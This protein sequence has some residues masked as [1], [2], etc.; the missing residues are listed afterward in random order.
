MPTITIFK[1]DLEGLLTGPGETRQSITMEQL[2]DSLMLVKGELKGQNP[3]SGELR[4]ELQD[5]NRPDLW[6]CEGI[7]RQIR[8]K[9]QGALAAY[10]FLTTKPKAL[11]RLHVAPGMEQVR[12]FVAA[13][14]ATGYRVT[15]EGLAQLI[16]T[17]EKLAEMFGRKRKTV[18][19]G[20]YRLAAIEFPIAYDL[21][22]P[23]DVSFMP[24]GM[25]TV[26]TL[27][28]MLLVHPKG[29]EFGEILA[30]Q[31]RLPVLRDATQQPLSFPPII[32]SREVGEVKVG[33][34]ALFVEVT[35]TDLPM[36]VLT[37]NIFAANLADRGAAIEPIDVRYPYKTALGQD[38][39]TPQDLKKSQTLLVSTIE[40]ALGQTLGAK[41]V[42]KAL[43]AY[44]Y[45][46]QANGNHVTVT[47]PPYRQDLMHAMDVVEDVAISRGYAD[48]LPV[49]PSDFTVGGLSRI[50]EVSDRV[51]ALMVGMGFQ[52]II[53]NILG[54]PQDLRDAMRLAGT[55]WGQLVEVDN[56]MSQNF[57]ALRQWML[58]SLLRV[59][60]ASNRAFYP[61]RLFEAGEVAKLDL[62][63]P[64]GSRTAVVLGGL[65]AHADAHFSEVHSCLD[66][67]FYYVNQAYSLEPIQ[68]P[69]FL[70]GRV[71]AI[72][73]EGQQIG[74]IGELHPEVL[75][76]WQISVPAVAF[77]IELTQLAE[78]P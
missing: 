44:G 71:G 40:Q 17:Q 24:L 72:V 38:V 63:Q 4:I 22:K 30:G 26:M 60:T 74:V 15:Q 59:E 36:V 13:C 73:C 9:R 35:G 5:S 6:C 51:R 57:S 54:S 48:F 43:T 56:V 41:E 46:V 64:L 12:P 18:S 61:H 31:D 77:E 65:I 8:V 42:V 68:H 21:V 29:L 14:T 67:L 47:L 32:N 49:M 53:S 20:I 19:I 50:E 45:E 55:E 1:Q 62:T 75:E 16:Q 34:D 58:P 11:K 69:S 33:D 25:D 66:T 7:A 27:G 70:A 52:E 2:E 37:L 28:E 3:D 78:R 39:V 10:K 76:R 23:E